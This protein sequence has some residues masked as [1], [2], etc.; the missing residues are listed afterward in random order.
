MELVVVGSSSAGN[1]MMLVA[2]EGALLIDAGFSMKEIRSRLG[3]E[4]LGLDKVVALLI[5]HEHSD[6][7]SGV[8]RFL[9]HDKLTVAANAATAAAVRATFGGDGVRP[10][11]DDK[12]VRFGPFAVRPIRVPHD[13]ADCSGFDIE[14]QGRHLVYATDLGAVPETIVKAGAR[15]DL[16]VLESNHD[17]EMLW[18]GT[19]PKFL[20]ERIGGGRGHLSNEQAGEAAAKM[21]TGRMRKLLLAHLSKE[22]NRPEVA[23]DGVRKGLH[24]KGALSAFEVEVHAAPKDGPLRVAWG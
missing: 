17:R 12:V 4:G 3:Q 23:L 13:S 11:E 9:R 18:S 6:H 8:G 7:A 1:S 14:V 22:N 2:D 15:A 5:T 20:K 24:G 21:A 10:L 19:Y 16:V